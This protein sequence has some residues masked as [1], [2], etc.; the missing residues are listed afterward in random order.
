[1]DAQTIN[2]VSNCEE[3]RYPYPDACVKL[4]IGIAGSL[5]VHSHLQYAQPMM[6][7]TTK[8]DQGGVV[9]DM[10]FKKRYPTAYPQ[11]VDDLADVR[12]QVQQL[13]DLDAQ[14]GG[15]WLVRWMFKPCMVMHRGTMGAMHRQFLLAQGP[16]EA[17]RK[18]VRR[19]YAGYALTLQQ[20]EALLARMERVK[21]GEE[22]ADHAWDH[23]RT[24][25]PSA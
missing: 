7:V 3:G 19:P 10:A 15:G 11:T 9:S 21:A 23:N 16:V 14:R 25:A 8:D 22:A 17:R 2:D 1:M 13:R 20:L 5:D 4:V 6:V 24:S 18:V 12:W